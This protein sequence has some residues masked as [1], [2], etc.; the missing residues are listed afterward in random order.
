MN[1]LRLMISTSVSSIKN[2]TLGEHTGIGFVFHTYLARHWSQARDTRERF[3]GVDSL[4][5]VGD[6]PLGRFACLDVSWPFMSVVT[7]LP[8]T[9]MFTCVSHGLAQYLVSDSRGCSSISDPCR[10]E[11]T[12]EH[13]EK[14]SS[15]QPASLLPR[16][17]RQPNPIGSLLLGHRLRGVWFVAH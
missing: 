13:A 6:V 9:M 17:V 11:A 8:S 15:R 5:L 12:G 16:Q 7:D 1:I 3:A 14:H 4:P 2:C 10:L